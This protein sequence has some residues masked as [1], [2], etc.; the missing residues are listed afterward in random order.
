MRPGLRILAGAAVLCAVVASGC[1]LL[2]RRIVLVRAPGHL[3]LLDASPTEVWG[4]VVGPGSMAVYQDGF[5]HIGELERDPDDP[6]RWRVQVETPFEPGIH[7]VRASL[8]TRYGSFEDEVL[9][10]IS[11]EPFAVGFRPAS[12]DASPG[13]PTRTGLVIFGPS[14]ADPVDVHLS[15][16]RTDGLIVTADPPDRLPASG[17]GAPILAR[18][19]VPIEVRPPLGTADGNLL[20]GVRADGP[21][22]TEPQRAWLSV[23]VTRG[24]AATPAPFDPGPTTYAVASRLIGRGA[25]GEG[26]ARVSW[27]VTFGCADGRCDAGIRNGGPRG[28]LA[29]TARYLARTGT[30]RLKGSDEVPRSDCRQLYDGTIEP[31]RWDDDG[32]WRF[33]YRIEIK[34]A[35]PD[36]TR[37]IQT[38]EGTGRRQ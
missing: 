34:L 28:G 3:D 8:S 21:P 29:W 1:E 20:V 2:D 15:V 4:Q 10:A 26:R 12:V 14:Q 5:G 13:T 32:P 35:C 31:T 19:T 22:G 18:T 33:G 9:F 6:T 16:E 24:E 11:D 38:W 7:S 27:Q 30:Y 25:G 36:R 37:T 17:M 23:R